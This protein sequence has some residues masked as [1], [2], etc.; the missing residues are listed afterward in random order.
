[1]SIYHFLACM[2]CKEYCDG[3]T[4]SGD[5]QLIDSDVTLSPFIDWHAN[6]KEI[7]ILHE[8]HDFIHLRETVRWTKENIN[9]LLERKFP[10]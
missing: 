4:T 7:K 1:M 5:H 10:L 2:D 6:C 9:S 8:D 3:S